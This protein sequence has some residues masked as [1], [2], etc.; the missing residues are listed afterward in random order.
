MRIASRRILL[1]FK[2]V[3]LR[4]GTVALFMDVI[5]RALPCLAAETGSPLPTFGVRT[6]RGLILILPTRAILIGKKPSC[7]SIHLFWA[8]CRQTG[9]W[10]ETWF[11]EVLR[12]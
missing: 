6:F 9:I 1:D 12:G 10:P 8:Y 3:H 2:E 5:G 7:G 11:R 4:R